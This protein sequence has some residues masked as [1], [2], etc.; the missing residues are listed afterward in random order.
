MITSRRHL[1][2]QQMILKAR[3]YYR[4]KCDGIWGPDTIRAKQDFENDVK[5]FAPCYPNNGMPFEVTGIVKY[6]KGIYSDP[7]KGRG[8]L[9][10]TEL[11]DGDVQSWKPDLVVPHDN[12]PENVRVEKQEPDQK[13]VTESVA[14]EAKP[15]QQTEPQAKDAEP[16]GRTQPQKNQQHQNQHKQN[17]HKQHRN[18]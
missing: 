5:A 17:K 1:Q 7:S 9:S 11:T 16:E 3:G 2:N 10:C 13:P 6:P 8:M 14:E 4:G 15:E 12:R 18:R